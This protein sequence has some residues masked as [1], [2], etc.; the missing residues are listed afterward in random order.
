MLMRLA[1]LRVLMRDANMAKL[2]AGPNAIA[3][4]PRVEPTKKAV[5]EAGLTP[6]N[7]RLILD[8]KIAEATDRLVRVEKI[9]AGFA[10]RKRA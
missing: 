4:T 2:D 6:K 5:A 8:E 1:R 3:F 9:L 10:G 7:G